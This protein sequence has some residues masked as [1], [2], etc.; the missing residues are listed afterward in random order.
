MQRFEQFSMILKYLKLFG[1]ILIYN[2]PLGYP[3]LYSNSPN[4]EEER[5]LSVSKDINV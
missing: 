1:T 4:E 3:E 2:C 5:L